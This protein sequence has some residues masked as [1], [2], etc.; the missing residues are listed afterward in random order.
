[1]RATLT[2]KEIR[3]QRKR[4]GSL[5]P[6]IEDFMRHPVEVEDAIDQAFLDSLFKKMRD[7]EEERR[8]GDYFFSPS[9]LGACLRYIFLSKNFKKLGID[10]LPQPRI[11]PHYYFLTGNFLHVKWQF[12][13][14]KMNRA[15]P[16]DIFKL[17]DVERRVLDVRGDHGG[18]IDAIAEIFTIPTIIDVKG[19][20][21]R[22]FGRVTRGEIPYGYGWQVADY[23]DLWNKEGV[24]G[25]VK[26]GILLAE[27]KGGP[28]PTHPVA[29]HELA[30]PIKKLK[31]E[32]H[33]RLK[34][35]RKHDRQKEIPEVECV[36]TTSL[37]FQGC[38]FRQYCRAEVKEVERARARA[39]S[40]NST[41][42]AV[43]VPKGR[44]T[45]SAR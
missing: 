1:M 4:G 24:N 22:D 29:L 3:R 14:H 10:K 9:S 31:P 11:E 25:K 45:R 19:L 21:V 18:T 33:A 42:V 17:I 12:V 7:R 38:P 20:N 43:A 15:L 5:V 28:D 32:I 16:D 30:V 41:R 6:L 23:A 40:G 26:S 8:E 34:E 44:R 27:K 37:Q 2:E 36:S 39:K 35:L 13:F